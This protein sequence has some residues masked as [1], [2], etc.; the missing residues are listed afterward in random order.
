M[1]KNSM[2]F[3]LMKKKG[4]NQIDQFVDGLVNIMRYSDDEVLYPDFSKVKADAGV[5]PEWFYPVFKGANGFSE[6]SAILQY[7]TE[8]PKFEN[9]AELMLGIAI[10]E[11]KHLDKLGDFILSLGGT[12][13]NPYNDSSIDYASTEE[14]AIE[15]AIKSEEATIEEYNNI[16]KKVLEVSPNDTTEVAMQFLSKLIA[17]EKKHLSLFEEQLRVYKNN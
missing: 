17:D 9:I 16:G 5:K 10:V 11:M 15:L 6:L 2:M 4:T 1:D 8:G 13:Q 3:A 7:T 14:E 12:I